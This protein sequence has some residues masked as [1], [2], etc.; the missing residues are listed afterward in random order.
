MNSTKA[1]VYVID[2]DEAVR[3]SLRF[4]IE[5][6]VHLVES[7]ASAHEFLAQPLKDDAGC[8]IADVRMP[9]MSGLELQ[10]ALNARGVTLS[11]VIITGHGDVEMAVRAMKNGAFDFVQKPFEDK[12]LLAVVDRAILEGRAVDA[13]RAFRREARTLLRQLSSRERQVLELIVA[14]VPNKRVAMELEISEKTVEAHRSNI[15][16]KMQAS[17]FAEL[18]TKVVSS[19]FRSS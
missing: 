5:S 6:D 14:G 19:E 11:L 2:D 13:D 18:V 16:A 7:F 10:E 8:V 3:A 9:G 17:S 12:E 1:T 4:L 15:M